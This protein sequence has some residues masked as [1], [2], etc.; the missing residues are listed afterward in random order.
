[1]ELWDACVEA[2]WSPV[3]EERAEPSFWGL[4]VGTKA[5][6]TG[7]A[8][9]FRDEGQVVLAAHRI[10][11]PRPGAPVDLADVEDAIRDMA[12]RFNIRR[13]YVDPFQAV[14]L[15]G[16]LQAAGI[17]AEE[18]AQ[19]VANTTRMGQTLLELIRGR[20]LVAYPDREIRQQAMNVVAVETPRGWR[21]AKERTSRKID[22]IAALSLA[23]VA[24]MDAPALA[25]VAVWGGWHGDLPQGSVPSPARGRALSRADTHRT[26]RR[27]GDRGARALQHLQ[28]PR[29]C[30]RRVPLEFKPDDAGRAESPLGVALG[31]RRSGHRQPPPLALP[32]HCPGPA[33]LR[34]GSE[35]MMTRKAADDCDCEPPCPCDGGCGG[36]CDHCGD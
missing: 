30:G 10:W 15:I 12:T 9:V 22:G 25:P 20:N 6:G 17:P 27:R 29:A 34:P 36:D 28:R 26:G 14:G 24:A 11:T 3:L 33:L 23:C 32:R 1:P 21:L 7:L 18:F 13:F 19:T 35:V 8:G 16:R 5:D 4:D 31:L 2:E